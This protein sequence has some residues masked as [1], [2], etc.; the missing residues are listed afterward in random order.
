VRELCAVG[1][2]IRHIDASEQKDVTPTGTA[3]QEQRG[4]CRVVVTCTTPGLRSVLETVGGECGCSM[5]HHAMA[6]DVK[7]VGVVVRTNSLSNNSTIYRDPCIYS[8]RLS[9]FY[10]FCFKI[11]K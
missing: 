7:R 5:Q 9:T 8:S 2:S 10:P 1:F 6:A 4:G 3:G 11:H